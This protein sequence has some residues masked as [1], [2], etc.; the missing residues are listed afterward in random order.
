VYGKNCEAGI[1]IRA[2]SR[3]RATEYARPKPPTA[4][5]GT[6]SHPP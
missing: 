4:S 1:L 2:P 3:K 5:A 6:P